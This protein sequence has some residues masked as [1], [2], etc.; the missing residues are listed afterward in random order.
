MPLSEDD[1]TSIREMIR[2]GIAEAHRERRLLD[3]AV[4]VGE[5]GGADTEY[6]PTRAKTKEIAD[7]SAK[8]AI[9]AYKKDLPKWYDIH[10]RIDSASALVVVLI[11]IA[12]IFYEGATHDQGGVRNLI[13]RIAGTEEK[14]KQVLASEKEGWDKDDTFRQVTRGAFRRWFEDEPTVSNP[15]RTFVKKTLEASPVLV[16]QGQT[17]FFLAERVNGDCVEFNL[18]LTSALTT[19]P[20]SAVADESAHLPD[21]SGGAASID[22]MRI[23][24]ACSNDAAAALDS[25]LDV[26]FFARIYD[27]EADGPADKVFAILV[28]K[29]EPKEG[30]GQVNLITGDDNGPAGL[31]VSYTTQNPQF[32]VE[33]DRRESLNLSESMVESGVGSGFWQVS[34]SDAITPHRGDRPPAFHLEQILHSV[35]VR[36]IIGAADLAGGDE[37]AGV[38]PVDDQIISVRV[39]V[40]VNKDVDNR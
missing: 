15:I 27:T 5:T 21:L 17:T 31:C 34:I 38:T 12:G 11:A 39:L 1:K 8:A 16:F 28:V 20:L 26:P 19:P 29:R 36:P 32:R 14:V 40:F 22:P 37:C 33:G 24:R 2:V 13:H 9:D 7:G 18:Q 4:L 30:T 10:R 23:P 35:N 6:V 25:P 3:P